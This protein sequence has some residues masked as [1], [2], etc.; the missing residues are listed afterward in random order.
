MKKYLS[1][2]AA[3][4][5]ITFTSCENNDLMLSEKKLEDNL[6]K[7]WKY[8][9]AN[10]NDSQERWTFENGIVTLTVANQVYT[11]NYKVDAKFS[12]AYVNLSNFTFN[13]TTNSG[14]TAADL[15]RAWTIVV[16]KDNVLYLSATDVRGAI[17]SLEY[18]GN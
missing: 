14:M 9:Y 1:I 11:G 12:K 4:L 5:M 18:I 17:R 7:T 15:N 8:L 2:I 10:S 13:G 3:F 6:E 16:L